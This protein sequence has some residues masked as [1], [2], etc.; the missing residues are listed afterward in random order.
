MVQK[1]YPNFIGLFQ[2]IF[3]T[4]D[5]DALKIIDD[6]RRKNEDSKNYVFKY[7]NGKA[8]GI[9]EDSIS[10]KN[11]W[12]GGWPAGRRAPAAAT[13]EVTYR[14]CAGSKKASCADRRLKQSKGGQKGLSC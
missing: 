9:K 11:V 10:K 3:K 7:V 4:L 13:H 2:W 12:C 6:W 5:N 8:R 1:Y 14:R